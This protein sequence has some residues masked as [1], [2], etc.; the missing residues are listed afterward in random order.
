[1]WVVV[2]MASDRKNAKKVKEILEEECI[3]VKIRG[4]G[5]GQRH[6]LDEGYYEVLV[7][8]SEIDEVRDC[9]YQWGL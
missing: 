9:L 1:M 4:E 2:Y 3:L 5:D 6:P 8:E 7:P